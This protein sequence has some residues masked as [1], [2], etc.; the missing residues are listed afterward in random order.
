MDAANCYLLSRRWFTRLWATFF[1]CTWM[2]QTVLYSPGYVLQVYELHSSYAHGCRKLFSNW[3]LTSLC[4]I[5]LKQ[6]TLSTLISAHRC[7]KLFSILQEMFDEAALS[8]EEMLVQTSASGLT[9]IAEWKYGKLEHKE[10]ASHS[11]DHVCQGGIPG[12]VQHPGWVI[13]I[14]Y[15]K[16]FSK[17]FFSARKMKTLLHLYC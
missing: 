17:T 13:T 12:W 9:Y 4:A 1:L 14:K 8:I 16:C 10:T 11:I 7:R 6:F 2:P 3:F 15:S 5:C